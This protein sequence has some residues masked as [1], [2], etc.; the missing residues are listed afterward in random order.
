MSPK[1]IEILV[2]LSEA[3]KIFRKLIKKFKPEGLI[4]IRFLGRPWEDDTFDWD[5]PSMFMGAP[6]TDIFPLSWMQCKLT[7]AKRLGLPRSNA[8][9]GSLVSTYKEPVGMRVTFM[10]NEPSPSEVF[11]PENSHLLDVID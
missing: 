8:Y 11:T 4:T 2:E 7:T 9:D 6:R 10:L 5:R 3:E 1:T